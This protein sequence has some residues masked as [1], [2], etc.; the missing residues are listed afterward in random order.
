MQNN[1]SRLL[2]AL[3]VAA[4]SA[5]MAK[6]PLTASRHANEAATARHYASLI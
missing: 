2:I 1:V 3:A 4:P 5:A 6:E